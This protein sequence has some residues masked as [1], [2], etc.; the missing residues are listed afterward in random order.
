MSVPRSPLVTDFYQLTMAQG[1]RRAGMHEHLACFDLFFREHPFQGG[2]TVFAGLEEALRFLEGFR[3]T[4]DDVA[5][6]REEGTFSAGFL[7]ELRNLRFTGEVDAVPEGTLVFPFEP[8]LRVIAPLDEAQL[9]ESTLLNIVNFQTLI[10]TKAARIC[11]EAG[12]DNVMEFGLRRAQGQDGARTAVRAAYIGGCVATSNVDAAKEYGIPVSGTHAH[13]WVMA[14]PG[15]LEAFRAYVRAY[16]ERAVLL[17]DT[18]DTLRSGVPNAVTVAR[19]MEARGERLF[20]VRLDS[21]DLAYLSIETRKQLDEAG[22]DYVK[23][24]ASSDLDERII[25]DLNIQGARIDLYGVG[26][27]LV[28]AH[29]DPALT[30]VYKLAAVRPP[31]EPWRNRLKISEGSKKATLPGVKQ[32]WRL[33]RKSGEMMADWIEIDGEEP[34]F[35]GGV[36]GYHPVL[37]YEKKFY[38]DIDRAENL[39]RP[40]FRKGKPVVEFPPLGEIRDRVRDRL[41][42]LHPTMRRLLN[43]HVYKVS[44]GPR[45]LEERR[46]LRE[47]ATGSEP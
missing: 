26:T 18:V 19:E 7:D 35:S 27:K 5:Y 8:M 42:T 11:R 15:E 33:Y 14:F 38:R 10:A 1:Y 41:E 30:G 31:G 13:S 21:G 4:D 25:H 22:L 36:W 40:V 9:V 2:F 6:L 20:G 43:P 46:R 17:V 34:D 16:P 44:I 37:E 29:G 3:F 12:R 39:L 47:E 24:V 28:T 23:I 45:L 32:I